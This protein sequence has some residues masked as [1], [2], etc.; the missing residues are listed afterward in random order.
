MSYIDIEHNGLQ[1]AIEITEE[2]DVRLLH[3]SA[4]GFEAESLGIEK[5]RRWFR[6]VELQATG[7]NQKFWHGAK[8]MRPS[9]RSA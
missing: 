4:L 8:Y 2:G 1:L 5:H 6:L 3:F 7:Y 9:A